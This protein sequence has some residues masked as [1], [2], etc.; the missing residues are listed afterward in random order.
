MEDSKEKNSWQ[1]AGAS[2][3]YLY[4]FWK[5]LPLPLCYV[6]SLH[7]ILDIN[8]KLEQVF[9]YTQVEMAGEDIEK[10]FQENSS[11]E[12]LKKEIVQKGSV[13]KEAIFLT[14]DKK[15]ILVSLSAI[16]RRD[17]QNYF[18]GYF[19]VIDRIH[20]NEEAYSPLELKEQIKEKTK[21][22]ETKLT[23]LRNSRLALLNMLE[24][25]EESK[26]QVEEEKERTLSIVANFVDGLINFDMENKMVLINSE[27]EKIF[28]VK[29]QEVTGK[30]IAE[31]A[32]IPNIKS[33]IEILSGPS[34][35][36][37]ID[38]IF[39][40]ELKISEK[41]ILEVSTIPIVKEGKQ[42]GTL[43]ILH[44][45]TRGKLIEKMKTEF[46]SISAHQL[47]TPL[48]AIKWTIKMLIDGDLGEVNKGQEEFLEK[49]YVSNERMIALINDLLDVTR[50]EEGRYIYDLTQV[51]FID[52]VQKMIDLYKNEFEKKEIK[53][54]FKKPRAVP[55]LTVDVEKINLVLQN[56]FDNALKYTKKDGEVS[57]AIEH[58]KK[59]NEMVFSIKDT[60]IGIAKDQQDR[61]YTRFFRSGNAL[62]METEGSGL[63]LYIAKN[64]IEAHHGKVWFESEEGKGSTFNFSL[65][66]K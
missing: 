20:K 25:A 7:F 52:L 2:E 21:E 42:T 26:K 12:E 19:L 17:R 59:K 50:I 43:V 6:N 49:I 3:G 47:R 10:F 55:K 22:L 39:K 9:G 61:I 64:I 4:D 51:S 66:A 45:V 60:G 18:N 46:V 15:E 8:E 11:M 28:S 38:E 56:L 24:D 13:K 62:R 14:K 5:F 32:K 30:S 65:P 34:K 29:N 23:E 33:L 58:D 41:L 63:G 16:A 1:E 35:H 37:K 44:D 31:L 40:K 48:S 53:F 57:V 54:G 36:V 27:A